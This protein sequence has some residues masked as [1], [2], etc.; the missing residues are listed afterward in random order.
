MAELHEPY[1]IPNEI[2]RKVLFSWHTEFCLFFFCCPL[3]WENLNHFATYRSQCGTFLCHW[4][5]ASWK[6]EKIYIFTE[7]DFL[8]LLDCS[9]ISGGQSDVDID[10]MNLEVCED[11]TQ[12][13]WFLWWIKFRASLPAGETY[14]CNLYLSQCNK[15]KVNAHV[16]VLLYWYNKY[17]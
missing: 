8:W 3:S 16:E 13:A 1:E 9:L 17:I 4:K 2:L 7:L 14:K 11:S 6:A 15:L 5:I 10:L 12:E